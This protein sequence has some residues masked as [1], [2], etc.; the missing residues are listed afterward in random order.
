MSTL[1]VDSLE[2]N[3]SA[4]NFTTNLTAGNGSAIREYYAQ[5]DKPSGAGNGAVWW[6]TTNSVYK[7]LIAGEWYTVGTIDPPPPAGD[8]AIVA[9]GYDGAAYF[10]ADYFSISTPGNA[11]SF[12]NLSQD[13]ESATAASNSTIGLFAGGNPSVSASVKTVDYFTFATTGNATDFGDLV[14]HSGSYDSSIMGSASDGTTALFAGGGTSLAFGAYATNVIEYFTFATPSNGTDF[15]DL[16]VTRDGLAGVTDRTYGV[17]AGGTTAGPSYSNVVDYVTIATP[18]NAVDFGDLTQARGFSVAGAYSATLGLFGGGRISGN[19]SNVI[20]YITIATPGNATDFGDL[21]VGRYTGAGTSDL[22]TAVFASGYSG[23]ST[24][25]NVID[26]VT[27]ATPGNATDFGDLTA[28]AG[29]TA[30]C[31]GD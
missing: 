29:N 19:Y 20:D 10:Q 4:V 22:T 3:G 11:V 23:T 6:D 14:I 8:R 16:S 1:K 15:G 17:F 12:G 2:N 21:T 18:G 13:R 31:S 24:R 7:M 9:S 26:Y 28:N 27:I 5:A 30:A 25:V